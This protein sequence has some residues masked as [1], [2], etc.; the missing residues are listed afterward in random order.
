MNKKILSMVLAIIMIVSGVP[1]CADAGDITVFL[2]LS[3]YGHIVKDKNN[4]SMAYVEV[5]LSGKSTYNLDDVFLE[6]H[7]RYF[8]DGTAGYSSSESE[9][10][11]GIDKLWGDTSCNFGYQVNGGTKEVSGLGHTVENEDYIDAFIY[12]NLYPD[13]EGYAMFDKCVAEA[14]TENKLELTLNYFSGYDENW[15]NIISPCEGATITVNGQETEFITDENGKAVITLE[16]TGKNIISATKK[17]IIN[18]EE[19]PAITAPICVVNT[20]V[21]PAIQ[22]IHNIANQYT[23]IDFSQENVNLP[24]IVA[25][26][27]VYE[28]LFPQ[29]QNHLNEDQK[30]DALFLFTSSANGAE[31]PGDLAKYI[32]ALR[33]LGYDASN[34]YNTNFEQTD[35]VKKLTDLVD[36]EDA[37]VANIYTTP[38]VLIALSQSVGYATDEQKDWLINTILDNKSMWQNTESGTDALTPMLLALA[39][40][41]ETNDSIDAVLNETVQILKSE[42]REDGLI[43]GFEGYEPASTGLA[44]CA[45]SS[46]G[47]DSGTIKNGEKS[48]ICGLLS[49][50]NEDLSGF[51]NAFATEQ[52]FRGLLAWRML[53]ENRN[54]IMYDFSDY[55]MNGINVSG[56]EYCPVIFDTTPENAKVTIEGKEMFSDNCFDL[57]KGKYTYSVSAEGYKEQTGEFEISDNEAMQHVLKRISISLSKQY[58]GG[59]SMSNIYNN[60]PEDNETKTDEESNNAESRAEKTEFSE[61]VFSDVKSD[62]WYYPAVQYVCD[63]DLFKGTVKGFEPNLPMTRAMLVTVLHRLAKEVPPSA[64]NLFSDVPENAWYSQSVSWAAEN[65]IINGVSNYSFDPDNIVTR[66]Q[67][68]V[69]LY[70]YAKHM[71][72]DINLQSNLTVSS[73]NDNQKISDY[74][75]DA[76]SYVIAIGVMN[77]KTQN[78]ICPDEGATRAEVATMLMRF[79][80][81]EK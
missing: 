14:Y 5:Q 61:T 49:S 54:R 56:I 21:N 25:D 18:A 9:W 31:K 13:T 78:A 51:S 57:D 2:S 38:Y 52:A 79:N 45:L 65:K 32:L 1:A 75:I 7:N 59:G 50:A 12:K 15:N 69:I 16:N 62:D 72:Y 34:V 33:S 23:Q 30:Q 27:M 60:D 80:E 3:Q 36:L 8:K 39:P 71:G 37:G 28:K 63:R 20:K 35:I 53:A 42:Q 40:Y 47:I 76:I 64:N 4:E 74:A 81:V 46:M 29:S 11:F 68:A 55:A 58:S 43:D 48:L 70:R 17:K 66:E 41:A 24:W 10:G 77:G 73:Y 26:M 19:V 44:I 67:L 22:I 6:A